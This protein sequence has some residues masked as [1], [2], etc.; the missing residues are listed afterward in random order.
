M[1]L[2]L[3]EHSV[4]ST[5]RGG[6]FLSAKSAI[7][8]VDPVNS[9]SAMTSGG[10]SGWASTVMPG[11]LSRSVEFMAYIQCNGRTDDRIPH[12]PAC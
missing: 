1:T 7:A 5:T 2:S 10:H 12:T 8:A 3:I 4:K 6:R 11:W 9:H